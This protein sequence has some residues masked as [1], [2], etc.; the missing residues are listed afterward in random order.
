MLLQVQWVC[1]ILSCPDDG[2]ICSSCV[3][4]IAGHWHQG[5]CYRHQNSG[6]NL[7]VL[8]RSIPVPDWV[9][10]L[11][12]RNGSGVD[13]FARTVRHS[14]IL[15]QK[16]IQYTPC[17]S[18][19]QVK[20]W[21][22]P[23]TST[24]LVMKGGTP[25][26]SILLAVIKG[27]TRHIHCSVEG[28]TPCTPI[29]LEVEMDIPCTSTLLAVAKGYALHVHTPGFGRGDTL[30]F[31]TAGCGKGYTCMSI[32]LAVELHVNTAGMKGIN[33]AHPHCWWGKGT[34]PARPC[35]WQLKQR[36]VH[37][38][39]AYVEGGPPHACAVMPWGGGGLVLYAWRGRLQL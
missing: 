5:R 16:Y 22:T 36:E 20:D 29:L 18:K 39:V 2:D 4:G 19:L 1:S 33:P 17:T 13:I 31:H 38:W 7:S 12:C 6:I 34:H 23:C 24:L 37:T 10:L 9:L 21:E 11:R 30:P 32:L 8:C 14:S 15:K 25:C 28:D 3:T 35:C 27:Y 26:T